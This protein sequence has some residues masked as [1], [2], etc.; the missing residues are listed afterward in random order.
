MMVLKRLE[1]WEGPDA[2]VPHG[3][4]TQNILPVHSIATGQM[5]IAQAAKAQKNYEL[6]TDTMN[7]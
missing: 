5:M 6:A 3:T 1:E 2:N 4:N 7:K